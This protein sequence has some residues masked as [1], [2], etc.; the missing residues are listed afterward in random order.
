MTDIEIIKRKICSCLALSGSPNENEAQTALKMARKL[1]AMYKIAEKD[2]DKIPTMVE[3]RTTDIT[4]SKERDPW[5]RHVL[6]TIC[7]RYCCEY[8]TSRYYRK[9]TRQIEFVG[10]A[11]DL[12]VCI[13]A[14]EFTVYT[15]RQNIA[16]RHLDR[17]DGKDYALGFVV[18]LDTAYKQQEAEERQNSMN[19]NGSSEFSLVMTVPKEVTDVLENIATEAPSETK[20]W[21]DLSIYSNEALFREGLTDGRNHLTPKISEAI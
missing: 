16:S 8:Y 11:D 21:N 20:K 5:I 17:E 3:T 19:T 13:R 15:I 6:K 12:S 7:N 1:M 18:G 10:Y 14:F 4:Y 2:L 9:R